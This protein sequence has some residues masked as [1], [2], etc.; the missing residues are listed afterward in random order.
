[1][2]ATSHGEEFSQLKPCPQVEFAP[3]WIGKVI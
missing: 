3:C 2:L 1:M